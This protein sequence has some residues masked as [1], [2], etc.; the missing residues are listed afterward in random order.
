MAEKTHGFSTLAVHAGQKP[1]P[2]TGAVMT[3]VYLTSTYAQA[4]PGVTKGYDYSRADHPTRRALEANLAALEG[5]RHG[6]A[7]SSGLGAIASILLC[8]KGGDHVVAGRDLYGGTYRLFRQVFEGFGLTFSFVDATD[9]EAIERALTSK[10]RL[11][12]LESPSNPLL[13]IT[14]LKAACALARPRGVEVAVDNTFASPALQNPLALGADLAVHSTTK[15]LGGHS[16]VVGG[17][18]MTDS[19]RWY[20]RLHF[21]Q[22]AVGA[23]PGPMDC[24]L[25]LRGT[26]TLPL[27]M[28]KHCANARKLA[29][30]LKVH[31]EVARVYYP[32]LPGHPGQALAARQM[33][34]FGGM[35]SFEL[36]GNKARAVRF[37]KA[38]RVFALAESLGGVESLASHP[39]TMTHASIPKPERE[40]AGLRDTLVRLSV[41]IE[42]YEDLLE[43][44]SHAI[45]KSK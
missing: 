2:A 1:D 19:A 18:V 37:L 41:G 24:F 12:W 22:K 40:K 35:L 3:P 39:A 43:D 34:D 21:M 23:V 26:K 36:H 20:E 7:F 33:K 28:E 44:L 27:R 16:D 32:G 31:P 29:A 17:C 5:A 15:Y 10:T 14:D 42:T 6:L 30:F 38:L 11:L 8:L 45:K 13:Q 25:V 4:A 9:L